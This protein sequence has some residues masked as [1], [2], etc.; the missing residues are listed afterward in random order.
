MTDYETFVSAV[1]Q[2][3]PGMARWW[4]EE[5]LI[6]GTPEGGIGGT[7]VVIGAELT[8]P[9]GG[10]TR[11]TK[12]PYPLDALN[13]LAG[14]SAADWQSVLGVTIGQQQTTI[15]QQATQIATLTADNAAAAA[16]IDALQ[17]QVATLTAQLAEATATPVG[18]TE[19]PTLSDG[20]NV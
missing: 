2:L 16:T 10:V 6:R 13:V 18:D 19:T 11:Q 14:Q 20:V 15:D 8:D 5:V 17:S 4:I 7:H 1:S 12:G 9:L 3:P